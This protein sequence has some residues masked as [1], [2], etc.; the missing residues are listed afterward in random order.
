MS[1]VYVVHLFIYACMHACV[2]YNCINTITLPIELN[3]EKNAIYKSLCQG[4][5]RAHPFYKPLTA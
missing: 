3:A 2:G 4:L 1:Y 5:K